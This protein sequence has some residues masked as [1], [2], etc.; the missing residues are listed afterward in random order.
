MAAAQPLVTR[1]YLRSL[2]LLLTGVGFVLG[3]F[4]LALV[5]EPARWW[6]WGGLIL[7]GGALGL[8]GKY[9]ARFAVAQ[10][11][12]IIVG[13]VVLLYALCVGPAAL[14]LDVM[15]RP[16]L[17]WPVVLLITAN[18]VVFGVLGWRRGAAP[19]RAAAAR[20][21]WEA[22]IAQ[23]ADLDT[24][25]LRLARDEAPAD[26]GARRLWWIA[27]GINVPLLAVMV[28]GEGADLVV[29][30][31][32]VAVILPLLSRLTQRFCALLPL[33]RHLHRYER[34]H[35]FRFASDQREALADVRSGFRLGR[36]LC[37]PEDR[38]APAARRTPPRQRR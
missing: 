6:L 37:R 10:G 32:V 20:G 3:L 2:P 30:L 17:V 33:Y 11:Q 15:G 1:D 29:V 5:P 28:F 21:A 24:R 4:L 38:V 31:V 14:A 8:Y 23:H 36:W 9:R 16:G 13:L 34:Q 25:T 22:A 27:L 19:W 26:D 12:V 18:F 35:G 7:G